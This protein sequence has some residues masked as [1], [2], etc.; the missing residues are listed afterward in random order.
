MTSVT[1]ALSALSVC[2][3]CFLFVLSATCTVLVWFLIFINLQFAG[4]ESFSP[5]VICWNSTITFSI[6][7]KY[8]NHL[9]DKF[10]LH[11]CDIHHI[12]IGIFFL[13]LLSII[14][15]YFH[16][17]DSHFRTCYHSVFLWQ[18]TGVSFASSSIAIYP[19]STLQC[20]N[21]ISCSFSKLLRC[22]VHT[23][24]FKQPSPCK[25]STFDVIINFDNFGWI[26]L[27]RNPSGSP[28]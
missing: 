28:K 14:F 5:Q 27:L 11:Y 4:T 1:L 7:D 25:I 9:Q 2:K 23:I 26:V 20:C 16:S 17:C 22:R 13:P 24:H 21:S 3:C 12:M 10:S 6:P 15:L 18:Q 8:S 19:I